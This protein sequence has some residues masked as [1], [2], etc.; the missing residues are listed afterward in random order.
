MKSIE[1]LNRVFEH[2]ELMVM[3]HAQSAADHNL[4][5]GWLY[6]A[7]VRVTRP[8]T[9]V[10]IGSWRGFVPIV[11]GR[12]LADNADGGHLH[13]IDPSMVDDFWADPQRTQAWFAGFGVDHVTHHLMTTQA[14]VQSDAYRALGPV[15]LLFVDGMHTAEQA[16]YDFEAFEALLADDASVFFH[17]SVRRLRSPIYGKDKVYEHSVVDYIHALRQDPRYQLMDY[18]HGSGVTLLRRAP[19]PPPTEV[20][21]TKSAMAGGAAT[22]APPPAPAPA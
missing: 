3:G 2:P 10:C 14:F 17:D 9:V 19:P 18:A 15:G 22:P 4:G 20:T 8:Q 7:Q 5:L 1:H 12:A 6:Y 13:F 16:R 21:L 11:L